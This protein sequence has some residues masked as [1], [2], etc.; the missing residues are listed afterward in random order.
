MKTR[1]TFFVLLLFVILMKGL[2]A[3]TGEP[4]SSVIPLKPQS[5]L[6]GKDIIINDLPNQNQRTVAICSAFNG[7][8]FSIYT[9][10]NDT[11]N[12][13]AFTIMKSI[14]N[15]ITWTVL[16]DNFWAIQDYQF[17]SMNIVAVGDSVSNLKV[18]MAGVIKTQSY[19]MG[20]ALGFRFNGETGEF[21]AGFIQE[22]DIY[23]VALATNYY[24][25]SNPS[26]FSLL[27][28]KWS[29]NKDSII[30]KTSSNGGVLLNI[31][32][33]VAF[34][35]HRYH[36]VALAYGRSS[37]FPN[38]N[39]YAAWEE[40]ADFGSIPGHI[41]TAHTFPY[42]NS[43]FTN[44]INLDSLY[45][46]NINKCRNPSIACQYNNTDND[47]ANLT[48]VVLFDKYDPSNQTYDIT[49]CYNLQAANHVN[50]KK[51]NISNSA[52]NNSQPSINFNPF[53]ST[54]MVT[55]YDATTQKLPFLLNNF[56]LNN[57]DNWQVVTTGY[58][59]DNNLAA[60][61]PKV[62]LDLGQRQGANVWS[63][64]GTGGN[65]IAMFDAPYSTYTGISGNNTGALARLIGAYPNPCSNNIKIAFE[66]KKSGKVTINVLSILGQPLGTVTDQYYPE[67]RHVV[68]YDVSDFP[69][70]TYFYNFRIGDFTTLGKFTVIR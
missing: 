43:G 33:A 12:F 1:V 42:Y 7:W 61:Y 53:D 56:N 59:D 19:D 30:F 66:L 68:R 20:E 69:A 18:S 21:E 70:G 29:L 63:R 60:P 64:E 10:V 16:T 45:A 49:G 36:K 34:S 9:Y 51:L 28:S 39:Y 3:Q 15:G 46:G 13:P 25:P 4:G 2:N 38:G 57:P 50:F 48:E 8:L 52:H 22:D 67:G 37:T 41:Y 14:D 26:T 24:Y 6:F 54:F 11:Y 44:P 40:H 55:F 47:S 58:N 23:D 27:F 35:S 65:G 5:P 32:K 31:R 17:K 62:A